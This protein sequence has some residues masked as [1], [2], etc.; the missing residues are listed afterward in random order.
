MSSQVK[1][2]VMQ[3]GEG[4][5]LRA[6]IDYFFHKMNVQ[7]V[8]DGKVVIKMCIRDRAKAL[9][10]SL[11]DD[12]QNMVRIDMSEYM[13]KH[14]VSRLIAVSYTHLDVYKRQAISSSP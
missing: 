14:S 6:F 2:T 7:G 12:E 5:F 3:F 11:F 1:E 4:G 8:Y 9:A 10:E 13:E